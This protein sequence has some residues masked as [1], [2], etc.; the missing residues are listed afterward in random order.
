MKTKNNE[1]PPIDGASLLHTGSID[2][3]ENVLVV[4]EDTALL[5]G[6]VGQ[7]EAAVEGIKGLGDLQGI[8]I[9]DSCAPRAIVGI[10]RNGSEIIVVLG[11]AVVDGEDAV[12]GG[13]VDGDGHQRVPRVLEELTGSYG[14]GGDDS[15]RAGGVCD[16]DGTPHGSLQLG[17]G[18]GLDTCGGVAA[19]KAVDLWTLKVFSFHHRN[20]YNK[21]KND[22]TQN[23]C[24]NLS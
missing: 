20:D 15:C 6:I 8:G 18:E 11:A 19:A 17:V 16:A 12:D 9:I 7:L 23:E 1:A 4:V 22:C 3:V 13:A 10:G 24:V 21:W 5:M 2:V 14:C